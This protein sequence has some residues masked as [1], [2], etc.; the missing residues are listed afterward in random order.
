M[1]IATSSV[2]WCAGSERGEN[3]GSKQ[4]RRT[5]P[6]VEETG[7]KWTREATFERMWRGCW[8]RARMWAASRVA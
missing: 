7:A 1:A 5:L 2:F 3:G 8:L 6:L 4:S